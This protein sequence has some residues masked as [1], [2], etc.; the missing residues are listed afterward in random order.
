MRKS[1]TTI[2]LVLCALCAYA[3]ERTWSF[4]FNEYWKSK[5]PQDTLSYVLDGGVVSTA[6]P[7][8]GAKFGTKDK[9]CDQVSFL[10]SA[11]SGTIK[12]VTVEA[13]RSSN[14]IGAL[15]VNVGGNDYRIRNS[16]S[17]DVST[18]SPTAYTFTG[19]SSGAIRILWTR[20]GG[21]GSL[22][23][24][25][26][27]ITYEMEEIALT[28]VAHTEGDYFA[29]FSSLSSDVFIKQTDATVS[30]VSI[31]E[32]GVLSI[33]DLRTAKGVDGENGYFIP[34]GAGVLLRKARADSE[35]TIHYYPI[36]GRN[37]APLGSNLLMPGTGNPTAA[38]QEGNYAF[39]RLAY[40]NYDEKTDLGFYYGPDCMNGEAFLCRAGSAYLAVPGSANAPAR[41]EYNLEESQFLS[42]EELTDEEE[43]DIASGT[44]A[45]KTSDNKAEKFFSGGQLLIRKDGAV[46]NA[47]GMRVK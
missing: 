42:Q 22:Y 18:V 3:A 36:S 25:S 4:T 40:G 9:P 15:T 34:Q 17:T 14:L 19:S 43:A 39:Y 28:M 20:T 6:D 8:T 31:D 41:A 44:D 27:S 5:I 26:I 29:T 46:F 32:E 13:A 38:P 30:T 24:K 33:A 11:F 2:L 23:V 21:S 35:T 12:S 37:I 7:T 45:A 47:M 1:L 10:S 16:T